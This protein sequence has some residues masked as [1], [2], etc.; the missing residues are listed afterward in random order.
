MQF[1]DE[2]IAKKFQFD[3]LDPTKIIP[4]RRVDSQ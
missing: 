2:S 4:V 1:F 3:F